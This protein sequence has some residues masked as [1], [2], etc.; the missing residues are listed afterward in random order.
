M[1]QNV[2]QVVN[3]HQSSWN[4]IPGIVS[5]VAQ[6]ESLL[7][8]LSSKLNAQNSMTKGVRIEKDVFMTA[9]INRMSIL[10]KGL[11]VHAIQTN[12]HVLFERNKEPKSTLDVT[13]EKRLQ[14]LTTALLEDLDTY[15]TALNNIGISSEVIQQFRDEALLLEESKNSVRQA[16][17]DRSIETQA[18]DDL[19]KQLNKFLTSQLDRCVGLLSTS[20]SNFFAE[21][22]AA[23]K[24]I[25]NSSGKNNAPAA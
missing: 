12:N 17:I 9:F 24:I 3:D 23:R 10:K 16:I 2:R 5:A 15:E 7:N 18:I 13:S 14:F 1:Y 22:K 4:Q 8:N 25:G 11:S 19:E 20:D 6:F 21:Y